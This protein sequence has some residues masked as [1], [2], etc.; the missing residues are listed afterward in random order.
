MRSYVFARAASPLVSSSAVT[1]HIL[2]RWSTE[3]S[4]HAR[5]VIPYMT[6]WPSGVCCRVF[7]ARGCIATF[8]KQPSCRKSETKLPELAAESFAAGS[9]AVALARAAVLRVPSVMVG[10]RASDSSARGIRSRR[11]CSTACDRRTTEVRCLRVFRLVAMRSCAA[12]FCKQPSRRKPNCP[13]C[14]VAY[15]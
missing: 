11:R 4:R 2:L 7:D 15:V 3:C 12:T 5:C 6:G 10:S 8:C 9:A 1:G 13:R 14:M